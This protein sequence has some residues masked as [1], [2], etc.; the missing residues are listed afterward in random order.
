MSTPSSWDDAKIHAYVD[1]A[2]D[3]DAAARL[4][5][6]S[7]SDAALAARIARQREVRALLRAEFDPVLDEP[8]PQRLLDTLAG[9]GPSSVVAPIGAARKER[10]GAP[11]PTWSLREWGAV[12]ATLALGVLLGS[13]L[14]RGSSSLPIDTRSGQFV[15]ASYLDAAL[16]TQLAGAAPEG[17]AARIDLSFRAADG[18]YCRTFALEVGTRGL[19]CRR[20][21]RWAV[22]LLE[23]AAA[24]PAAPDGFRQASSALSPAMLGAMNALGA[25]EPLTT[26]EEQQRLGSGWDAA[27]Q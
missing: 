10:P 20:D 13:Q 4:E 19:A 8:I 1:G 25:S 23:A 7:G 17:A 27:G 24:Q 11:R 26:E 21:G 22:E 14:F 3:A 2:L 18:Q 6:D 9:P 15:A 5:R 12:A 16:S